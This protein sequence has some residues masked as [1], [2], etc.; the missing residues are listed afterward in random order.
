MALAGD[1]ISS[2]E[3]FMPLSEHETIDQLFGRARDVQRI[4]ARIARRY[5]FGSYEV[6]NPHAYEYESY[7]TEYTATH[8]SDV[9]ESRDLPLSGL[10][11]RVKP[12]QEIE[13][14]KQVGERACSLY[15]RIQD[16]E[17]NKLLFGTMVS[18]TAKDVSGA[19]I[20]RRT[21]VAEELFRG[22]KDSSVTAPFHHADLGRNCLVLAAEAN[23]GNTTELERHLQYAG[24]SFTH[25]YWDVPL[26]G[27]FGTS[28]AAA[29]R[30]VDLRL[31]KL[32]E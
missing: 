2:K 21:F 14:I 6:A 8:M 24:Y 13:L 9:I 3:K 11:E 12:F 15:A 32:I 27:E 25:I 22:E 4:T 20:S 19:S 26:L 16:A 17:V 29:G 28:T 10:I 23:E 18:A 1:R 30:L 7:L 5:Q 31:H